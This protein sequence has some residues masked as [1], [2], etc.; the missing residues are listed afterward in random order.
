MVKEQKIEKSELPK[1][2]VFILVLILVVMGVVGVLIGL[3]TWKEIEYHKAITPLVIGIVIIEAILIIFLTIGISFGGV[4]IFNEIIE[5]TPQKVKVV[6][7]IGEIIGILC[8]I[9]MI[10]VLLMG[11]YVTVFLE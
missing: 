3:N 10:G 11:I 4:S 7:G 8:M 6:I 1:E 5:I 9:G 2:G